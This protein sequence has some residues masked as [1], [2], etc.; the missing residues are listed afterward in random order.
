HAGRP[1]RVAVSANFQNVS[2]VA[3]KARGVSRYTMA[4][5]WSAARAEATTP[6][7]RPTRANPM[8]P[9]NPKASHPP[10]RNWSA[11]LLVNRFTNASTTASSVYRP[12]V[13][14]NAEKAITSR[15][16]HERRQPSTAFHASQ[17]RP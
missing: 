13:A 10:P 6:R 16:S 17:G 12:V 9:D 5:A 2:R 1:H 8:I 7:P 4:D 3:H 14:A 15:L 11:Q